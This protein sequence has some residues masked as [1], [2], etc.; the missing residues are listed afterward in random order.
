MD[1]AKKASQ[2]A[3]APYS[4]IRVSSAL[5]ADN[6]SI[7]S[8]VNVENASYGATICAERS[9]CAAMAAG[10]GRAITV[11]AVYSPDVFPLPCG[12]CLQV[13]SEFCGDCDIYVESPEKTGK[14][15]LSGLLPAA[16]RLKKEIK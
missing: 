9:A 1:A 6:G 11:V 7:Y 4:G 5:L 10:G 12:I 15:R 13:L 3:Y 16:F 8:G 14:Y 2:N